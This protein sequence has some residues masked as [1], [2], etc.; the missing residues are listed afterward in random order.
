MIEIFLNKDNL[1]KKDKR[2]MDKQYSLLKEELNFKFEQIEVNQNYDDISKIIHF[3]NSFDYH[4]TDKHNKI[5]NFLEKSFYSFYLRNI[6][7]MIKCRVDFIIYSLIDL[8]YCNKNYFHN[9][10][11]NELFVKKTYPILELDT[12]NLSTFIA[13]ACIRFI[14]ILA[15]IQN[16]DFLEKY[17]KE[18]KKKTYDFE[19][20]EEIK[21]IKD[22]K[23]IDLQREIDLENIRKQFGL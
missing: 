18:S 8:F 11:E 3:Y 22:A 5:V 7:E 14:S 13:I 21:Y 1:T 12:K 16:I 6:D 2:E 9:N 23:K 15:A 4:E 20:M 19:V 10:V 17:I